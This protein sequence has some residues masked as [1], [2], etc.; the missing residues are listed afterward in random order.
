[1]KQRTTK[2]ENEFLKQKL[3]RGMAA[4]LFNL[5]RARISQLEHDGIIHADADGQFELGKLVA[6]WTAHLQHEKVS[7]KI[8]AEEKL[9]KLKIEKLERDRAI[10]EKDL[11]PFAVFKEW[12]LEQLGWLMAQYVSLPQWITRVVPERNRILK[13]ITEIHDKFCDNLKLDGTVIPK[14]MKEAMK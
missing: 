2:Q 9:L 7:G 6:D 3:S 1:M 12:S 8:A 10:A 4:K 14:S 13:R 11:V 5:T